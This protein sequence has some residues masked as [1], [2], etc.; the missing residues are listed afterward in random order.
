MN[1]ATSSEGMLTR[2][3]DDQGQSR[4]PTWLKVGFTLWLFVLIPM[5]WPFYGPWSQLW[6]CNLGN[7]VI[8][9][10]LWRESRLLFSWQAVSLLLI[11]F[12]FTLDYVGRWILGF[13]PIGGT[14]YMFDA[15]RYPLHMRILSLF[16]LVIPVLLVWAI[17]RLGYDRSAMRV[18]VV[19]LW[20]LLP[21]C[22]FLT[23]PEMDVNYV[24]GPFDKP[25]TLVPSGLY[26]LACMLIYPLILNLPT[27]VLLSGYQRRRQ[28]RLTPRRAG[29]SWNDTT[30][31][32]TA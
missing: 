16:H 20:V 25:Q 32:D 2:A 31:R 21:L 10:A 1:E 5:D 15:V 8:A 30:V 7:I 4:I 24:F 22:Y 27:H 28:A 26:L 14:E 19:F 18:Q 9:I 17:R 11:D 6:F 13:H 12:T 29:D 3:P 23:P